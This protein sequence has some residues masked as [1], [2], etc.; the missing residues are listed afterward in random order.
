MATTNE[1]VS[2]IMAKQLEISEANPRAQVTK[3][4]VKDIVDRTVDA[5]VQSL[6]HEGKVSMTFGTFKVK[7]RN[8]RKG[9]NPVSGEEIMI[10]ATKTVSFK[11]SPTLK[12]AVNNDLEFTDEDQDDE[13]QDDE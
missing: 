5:I 6:A 13:D 4:L 7:Q 9:R 3:K 11:A 1:I 2:K 12:N 10:P 8:A